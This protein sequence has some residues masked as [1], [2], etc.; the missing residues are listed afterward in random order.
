[1][2]F[3]LEHETSMDAHEY[4]EVYSE[5]VELSANTEHDRKWPKSGSNV[6][7]PYTISNRFTSDERATIA[8]GIDDFHKKTCLK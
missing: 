8:Q 2:T 7:I 6:E 1:M 5:A 4:G 3:A